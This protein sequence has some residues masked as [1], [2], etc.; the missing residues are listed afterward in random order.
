LDRVGV[1]DVMPVCSANEVPG[2]LRAEL[3]AAAERVGAA[4]QPCT[5]NRASDHWS[6]VRNGLPGVRL[7]STSYAGYH[8]PQDVPSVVNRAQLARAARITVAWLSSR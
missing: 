2:P 1:G 8:S 4:V 3:V 6:F 7:G 5:G